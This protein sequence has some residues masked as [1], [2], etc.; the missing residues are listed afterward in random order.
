MYLV[1][2]TGTN[3]HPSPAPLWTPHVNR[4]SVWI[5]TMIVTSWD[6][7]LVPLR[8]ACWVIILVTIPQAS[9]TQV[10]CFVVQIFVYPD[11]P[12]PLHLNSKCITPGMSICPS[13]TAYLFHQ[14]RSACVIDI[15]MILHTI[16]TMLHVIVL[17]E[18][19]SR[20]TKDKQNSS[21]FSAVHRCYDIRSSWR[22]GCHHS[23]LSFIIYFLI[24]STQHLN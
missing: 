22:S 21:T 23:K 7:S 18:Y 5:T 6:E 2:T 8:Q 13:F 4:S 12:S 15:I 20:S 9:S 3:C 11:E 14:F 17:N 24:L 1:D 16:L 19:W 10:W